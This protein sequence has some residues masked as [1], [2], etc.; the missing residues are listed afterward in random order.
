MS[1]GDQVDMFLRL[2]IAAGI[3]SLVGLQR[4]YRG[5]EAGIRTTAMVCLGAAIFAEL[6]RYIGDSRI[7]AGV[8]QGIGFLG[9]GL[10]Y[11]RGDSTQGVTTAATVWVTAALGLVIGNDLPVTGIL[12]ALAL[13]VM[14]ELAP[15]SDWVYARGRAQRRA[16]GVREP[17]E[18]YVDPET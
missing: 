4:E 11:Q 8:V 7:A 16:K 10:I 5:H 14:L 3:G 2:L 12:L 9:A 13:V 15:L 17:G 1:N 18:P 6:S